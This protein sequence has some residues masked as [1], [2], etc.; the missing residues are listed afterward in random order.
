MTAVIEMPLCLE[1]GLAVLDNG[2]GVNYKWSRM[3]N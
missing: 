2:I 3:R 1:H